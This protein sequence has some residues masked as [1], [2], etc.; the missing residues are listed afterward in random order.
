MCQL[1]L[2]FNRSLLELYDLDGCDVYN[3]FSDF[4][5]RVASQEL[6]IAAL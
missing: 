5:V 4:E 2:Q 6:E 1:A 3:F